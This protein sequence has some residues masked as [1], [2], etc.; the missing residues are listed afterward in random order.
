MNELTAEEYAKRL[1]SLKKWVQRRQISERG[2]VTFREAG[3]RYRVCL[4]DVMQMVEDANL[5][6]NVG[7]RT[8]AGHG[9]FERRSDYTIE[10]LN[11]EIPNV[12]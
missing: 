5:T 1:D 6:Y 2:L 9:V 3:H 10:D 8:G 12:V 11:V 7:I 4:D